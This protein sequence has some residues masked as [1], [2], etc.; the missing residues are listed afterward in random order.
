MIHSLQPTF[1]IQSP[2]IAFSSRKP[3]QNLSAPQ[4]DSVA[5]RFGSAPTTNTD[6]KLVKQFFEAAEYGSVA[7]VRRL[8][9]NDK[10]DVN[11]QHPELGYTALYRATLNQNLAVVK[12]LLKAG[13]D[14][15]SQDRDGWTPLH[16][17]VAT[18]VDDL[19]SSN[20]I[21][22]TLLEAGAD[23]MIQ[24]KERELSPIMLAF[25][26][27]RPNAVKLLMESP[28]FKQ[29]INSKS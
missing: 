27:N 19:N 18:Q 10:V 20:T 26:Y 28:Q 25:K 1:A 22:K 24:S 13:A 9:Q 7:T 12:A 23:P 11:A 29:W 21:I 14:C 4:A 3:S 8:I 5:I 2:K 16:I 6:P 15:N 17:A